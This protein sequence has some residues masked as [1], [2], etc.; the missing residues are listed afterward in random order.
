[1]AAQRR[2]ARLWG[3]RRGVRRLD[4]AYA[5]GVRPAND[6]FFSR[7]GAG[8]SLIPP[9]AVSL[10]FEGFFGFYVFHGFRGFVFFKFLDFWIFEA[11]R[12][13]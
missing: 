5:R 2:G 1:M 9:L 3:H 12:V 7:A 11:F 6:G 4:R 13:F 8:H 10:G